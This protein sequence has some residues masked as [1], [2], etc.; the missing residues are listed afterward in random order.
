[1]DPAAEIATPVTRIADLAVPVGRSC[2]L[3][4][5]DGPE[6]PWT[7]AVLDCLESLGV[8]A[9]FFVLGCKIAGNERTLRR[10]V[11]LGCAV[12]VHSWEHI[13]MTDQQPEQVAADIRRTSDLIREV[14]GRAP[15][16]VRP[17]DGAVSHQVLDQIR[18]SGMTPAFWSN[19]AFDW[20]RPGAE[21]I[22]RDVSKG[23]RNGAVVLLHDGGGDRSQ[24]VEAIPGI[25]RV[26][27]A[28]GLLPVPLGA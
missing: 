7:G 6:E 23:L 15:R 26:A 9:T 13:R 1:M 8:V 2:A 5:D 24:T 18:L 19:H 20:D 27:A 4:F 16:F 3:T 17:P 22:V 21:A 10:M 12:E 11:E 28:R 25:V 14:T